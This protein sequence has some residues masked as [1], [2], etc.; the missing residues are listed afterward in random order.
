MPG[1][2][3]ERGGSPVWQGR[4]GSDLHDP[5]TTISIQEISPN[6]LAKQAKFRAQ[7]SAV[8]VTAQSEVK[9]WEYQVQAGDI[10]SVIV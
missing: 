2:E 3:Y 6:L 5:K 4:L 7:Q 9:G 1:M 10:L 8:G